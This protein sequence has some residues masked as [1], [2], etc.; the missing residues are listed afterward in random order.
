MAK[1]IIFYQL[2]GKE[3][4]KCDTSLIWHRNQGLENL[5]A[6]KLLELCVSFFN[7]THRAAFFY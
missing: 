6:V 2:A 7:G 4:N 5:A 1:I 3:S